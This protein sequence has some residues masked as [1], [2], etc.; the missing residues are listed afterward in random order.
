MAGQVIHRLATG[1]RLGASPLHSD[2]SVDD[3]AACRRQPW[4]RNLRHDNRQE[5]QSGNRYM[6]GHASMST[7]VCTAYF[8]CIPTS[9]SMSL[10]A[11]A[12]V[13]VAVAA[14]TT[15]RGHEEHL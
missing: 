1:S 7:A 3:A 4:S 8:W 5:L 11:A 15:T 12:A 13:A 9:I 10:S 6:P 14:A 2:L